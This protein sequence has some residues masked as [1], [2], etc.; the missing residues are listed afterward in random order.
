MTAFLLFMG[1]LVVLRMFLFIVE[2]CDEK[3][4]ESY[5]DDDFYPDHGVL[6]LFVF[7]FFSSHP[8]ESGVGRPGTPAVFL[9]AR[10]RVWRRIL[11]ED[12][13]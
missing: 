8:G 1:N 2:H 7:D 13:P 3:D 9:P 12:S 4:D 6:G 11:T 10:R 5:E